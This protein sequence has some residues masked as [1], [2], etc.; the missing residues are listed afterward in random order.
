[1]KKFYVIFISIFFC[2]NSAW[3]ENIDTILHSIG[4]NIV[5]PLEKGQVICVLDFDTPSEQMSDYIQS[6]L[7]STITEAGKVKVVTRAHMDKVNRE[8][9]FQ[10]SGMVD[11]EQAL[12]F[13]KRLGSNA[14]VFGQLKELDN[15]YNLQIKMLDVESGSYLLFHT[16][17][18]NRTSK[19][20]QLLGRASTYYKGALGV[21]S[22]INKNSIENVA[23][24]GG[25]SF[26]Y[27]IIRKLS[28]GIKILASGD[29]FEKSASIFTMEFLP[30]ARFYVCSASGEPVT[31]LYVEAQAGKTF[32]F[33]DS[34]AKSAI[35]GGIAV[36]YRHP[37]DFLFIEPSLR[38]GYPYL[39]GIGLTIGGRF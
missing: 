1:M 19:S 17:I 12:S 4:E 15:R 39:F 38:C 13:C 16:Y 10:M 27:A 7:I 26:D 33:V 5:L 23:F 11:E 6:E 37:F 20:E 21:I 18:F 35:D 34:E 25:I 8:L 9:D 31:G 29:A 14:I 22:E 3:S 36:G 28:A 2:L 24:G 32:I 30:F